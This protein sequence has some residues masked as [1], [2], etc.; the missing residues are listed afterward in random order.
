MVTIKNYF[1]N[2]VAISSLKL[3]DTF[4]DDNFDLHMITD[5]DCEDSCYTI[6]LHSGETCAFDWTE[7]VMP[8][9]LDI[10]IKK[11]GVS[12]NDNYF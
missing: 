10:T 4:L 2:R 7:W 1:T 3:G 6:C 11:R 8:V 9:D 12:L 5:K